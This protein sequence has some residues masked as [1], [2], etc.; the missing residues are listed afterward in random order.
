M[1]ISNMIN[2]KRRKMS[3][4]E[5]WVINMKYYYNGHYLINKFLYKTYT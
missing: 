1:K 2:T 4:K 3:L 5:N